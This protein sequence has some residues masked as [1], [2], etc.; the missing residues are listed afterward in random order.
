MPADITSAAGTP[1]EDV[2]E[3]FQVGLVLPTAE[4]PN[5][6]FEGRIGWWTELREVARLAEAVGIDSLWVADHLLY[7]D[8]PPQVR[9]PA[10]TTR[11]IWECWTLLA[12]L[13]EA[14]SRVT[15]GPFVACTGFRN[16]AL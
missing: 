13:A 15:L 4:G 7:R 12:A 2:P 5:L 8:A 14:T 6:G 10:G 11:G 3:P 1:I 9:L 16:P